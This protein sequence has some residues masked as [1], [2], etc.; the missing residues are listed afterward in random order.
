[1]LHVDD[2]GI[3]PMSLVGLSKMTT[4]NV[5]CLVSAAGPT[6]PER[7]TDTVLLRTPQKAPQIEPLVVETAGH[8]YKQTDQFTYPGGVVNENAD[9]IPKIERRTRLARTCP[10]TYAQQPYNQPN[11]PFTLEVRTLKA[12]MVETLYTAVRHGRSV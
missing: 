9:L 8:R 1:M 7:K 3:A 6:M 2:T 10:K 11:A 4:V 5:K 12:D